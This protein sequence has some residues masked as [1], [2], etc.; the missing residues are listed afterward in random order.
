M[1]LVRAGLCMALFALPACS[2]SSD[3][4]EEGARCG[5]GRLDPG[6]TCDPD[7]PL[8]A[9][10]CPASCDD[11]IACTT[12]TRVGAADACTLRCQYDVV[13]ACLDGDGCCPS[14]CDAA[15]DAD[16]SASC[17]DGILDPG[18]TCDGDCVAVCSDED[19]CTQN[20]RLGSSSDCSA[21]CVFLPVSECV[22]DDDCC[23]V[24]C[25]SETDTDCSD[26]CGDGVVDPDESCDGDCPTSCEDDGDACT[27]EVLTGSPE[28]CSVTCSSRP[29]TACVDGDGCCPS[30]CSFSNDDDC[31][32]NCGNGVVDPG[33]TCDGNCLSS[34]SGIPVP[35]CTEEVRLEGSADRCNVRCREIPVSACRDNDL[36]CP[37]GCTPDDD[38][39]C[40][41][42]SG[43]VGSP[44]QTAADCAGGG[45][46]LVSVAASIP[47]V[48]MPGGYCSVDCESGGLCPSGAVC[49]FLDDFPRCYDACTVDGD[50]RPGYECQS[51]FEEGP[52]CFPPF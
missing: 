9:G 46:C 18:E 27:E 31:E 33:E 45:R 32:S 29:L 16:C 11:G 12:D 10:R 40:A 21:E 24:G 20:R 23:A 6:E 35:A 43:A 14:A 47:A 25:T 39:D 13:T 52:L 7:A 50:C 28:T 34:C 2:D 48:L 22:A 38:D 41:V 17:G 1:S 37:S 19:A 30:S 26:S 51:P 42:A 15:S 49:S 36:C 5:N 44:C 4:E 8:V 3:S